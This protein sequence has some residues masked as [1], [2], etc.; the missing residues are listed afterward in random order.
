MPFRGVTGMEALTQALFAGGT[1][2]LAFAFAAT[3]GHAVLLAS[4]RRSLAALLAP[5]GARRPPLA[6]ARAAGRLPSRVGR[7]RDRVLRR[8]SRRG[9]RGGSRRLCRAIAA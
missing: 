4:G 7:R 5:H 8:I 6:H 3:I 1:V 2:V 9:R